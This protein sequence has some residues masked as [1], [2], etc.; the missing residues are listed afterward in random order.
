V[1]ESPIERFLK[2]IDELDVDGAMAVMAPGARLLAVDGRRED[3]TEAVR[4]VVAE[5]LSAL[6]ST[7]HRV[8]AQWHVDSVW[9]AE[10]EATYEL[11]DWL[12]LNALPRAFV[13]RMAP[14]GIA[15]LRVY[16][17]HERPLTEHRTGEEGMWV[18]GR[19]VPPL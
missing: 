7:E 5:L 4:S 10:V 14:E 2:A 17:A 8:S 18:G 19:W 15:D 12:K 3:G 9:I 16:G 11:R 6:R 1:S 13:A